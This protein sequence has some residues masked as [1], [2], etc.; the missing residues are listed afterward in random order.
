MANILLQPGKTAVSGNTGALAA[1][2]IF[3]I[4]KGVVHLSTDGGTTKIPFYGPEFNAENR[5][6]KVVFSSG[7]T[8]HY[9]NERNSDAELRHMAM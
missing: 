4:A 6:E 5:G 9:F 8:V 2:N 1:D 3:F 7:L